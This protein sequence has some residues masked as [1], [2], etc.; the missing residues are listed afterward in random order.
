[1]RGHFQIQ[2][3]PSHGKGHIQPARTQRKHSQGAGGRRVTVRTSQTLS[4]YPKAFH[5]DRMTYSVPG[6]A[7]P[8]A[9][10]LGRRTKKNM[11][12]GIPEIRLQK[13]VVYVLDRHFSL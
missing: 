4:G 13:V 2:R 12:V 3:L 6:P 5:M 9:E 1:N 7:V 11:I 8:K 10:A